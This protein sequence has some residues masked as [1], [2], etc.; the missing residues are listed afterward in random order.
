M[1]SETVSKM[2][3]ILHSAQVKVN[4]VCNDVADFQ[5]LTIWKYEELGSVSPT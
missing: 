3:D 5:I 2:A 1:A 4:G